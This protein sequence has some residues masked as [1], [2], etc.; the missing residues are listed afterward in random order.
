M[1][2]ASPAGVPD[3]ASW[4]APTVIERRNLSAAQQAIW[5]AEI[6]YRGTPRW[7]QITVIRLAG[8]VD[9]DRLE[10]ALHA[11]SG[12]FPAT[13]TRLVL[14]GN[15]PR[16]YFAH[17]ETLPVARS[18]LPGDKALSAYLKRAA[19]HKFELY[20]SPLF[21]A[22]IL[23]LGTQAATLVLVYHH[24]AVDGVGSAIFIQRVA[25]A[26]RGDAPLDAA[27]SSAYAQWL[28]RQAAETSPIDADL[29][30]LCDQ[31]VGGVEHSEALYDRPDE[32]PFAE[33][34]GLPESTN[35]LDLATSKALQRFAKS[36]QS[37]LFLVL[38]AAYAATL[39]EMTGA[40]DLLIATFA[41]GRHREPEDLVGMCINTM[42]VRIRLAGEITGPD[43]VAAV[44]RAW[45]SVRRWQNV[46]LARLK[47]VSRRPLPGK[48]Q[49]A[50]NYLD[51]SQALFELP[52]VTTE[53]THIQQGYPPDDL[54]FYC[55]REQDGRIRLRLINGTGTPALSTQGVALL[56]DA[57][58]DRLSTWSGGHC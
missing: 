3:A 19:S 41:S 16:Q 37:T 44:K 9:L 28:D 55:L 17:H 22:E 54:L 11:A 24:A 39:A 56:M 52:G 21:R 51:M 4:D 20:E 43:Y 58:V 8:P 6:L 26:Y 32:G 50:I 31:L 5:L 46:P 57:V 12:H 10:M 38:F 7:T 1:S 40:D 33:P 48:A 27:E 47:Q 35:T 14:E 15:H 13:R 2:D 53:V 29:E 45:S 18:N 49:F 25:A 23:S 42:L 30:T 36:T 34:P